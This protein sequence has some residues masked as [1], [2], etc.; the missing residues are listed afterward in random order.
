MTLKLNIGTLTKFV[1]Y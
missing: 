1:V